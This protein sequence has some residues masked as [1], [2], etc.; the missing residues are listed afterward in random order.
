MTFLGDDDNVHMNLKNKA[1]INKI[2]KFVS[3][4]RLKTKFLAL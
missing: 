3:F 1:D 4:K 2:L